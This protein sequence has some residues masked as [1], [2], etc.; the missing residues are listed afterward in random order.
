MYRQYRSDYSNQI[1]QF[2]VSIS[3]HLHVT[4]G[5]KLKYQKKPF[6]A[7][8]GKQA[9]FTRRHVVN[10]LIRDHF[11]GLFYAEITDIDNVYS[12]CE[13]LHRAWSESADHP[14]YGVPDMMTLPKNVR[15]VWPDLAA[16]L[17]EEASINLVDVTS[18][19]Q[20]GVRDIRTWEDLLRFGVYE[21]GFPPDYKEVRSA[22]VA[23][24]ARYNQYDGKVDI[25]TQN[26]PE[27]VYVPS[28]MFLVD[29]LRRNGV[30][31][32]QRPQPGRSE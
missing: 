7:R 3:R 6:D 31:P 5:G 18:G 24:C 15:A 8:L 4:A 23:E 27:N 29:C 10:F 1:P 28:D 11:S 30:P 25:W 20:G 22:A 9:T 14:L 26:L 19:F 12:A 16:F 17:E 2:I 21:S 32:G 13:F